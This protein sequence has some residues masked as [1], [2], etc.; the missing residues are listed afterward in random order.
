MIA[1]LTKCTEVIAE[2][3]LAMQEIRRQMERAADQP[4]DEEVIYEK[5]KKFDIPIV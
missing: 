4:A 2:T 3:D 1:R 5:L